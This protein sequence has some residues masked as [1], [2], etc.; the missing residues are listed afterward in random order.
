MKKNGR[1][2]GDNKIRIVMTDKN[3]RVIFEWRPGRGNVAK[4]LKKACDVATHKLGEDLAQEGI[5][6]TPEPSDRQAVA[7]TPGVGDVKS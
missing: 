4:G 5:T 6:I 1:N 7:A 2:N 3:N